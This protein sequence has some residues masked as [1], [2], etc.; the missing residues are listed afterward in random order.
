M[1]HALIDFQGKITSAKMQTHLVPKQHCQLQCDLRLPA[2]KDNH[3]L[4]AAVA[5]R[6]LRTTNPLRSGE[7][8]LQRAIAH[9]QRE[10][11]NHPETSVTACAQSE[12]DSAAK[13]RCP[14]PSHK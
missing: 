8:E 11:K 14:Q 2:A 13:R 7:T 6:L 4:Q 9:Q 3:V 10:A 5:A 1:E 12:P